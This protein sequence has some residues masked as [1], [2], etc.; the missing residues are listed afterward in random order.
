MKRI[1]LLLLSLLVIVVAYGLKGGALQIIFVA[2]AVIPLLLCTILGTLFSFKLSEI[3]SAFRD[4]FNEEAIQNNTEVYK[5]DR[6]V[7][8]N[9]SSVL[10]FW[11]SVIVV[12][13]IVTALS[14]ISDMTKLGLELSSVFTVLTLGLIIKALLLIPM[15]ISI[16]KKLILTRKIQDYAQ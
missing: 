12:L 5:L 16:K 10:A 14:N 8:R 3:I 9:I 7:I 1:F 6:L 15:E 4:A 11:T 2:K 13:G